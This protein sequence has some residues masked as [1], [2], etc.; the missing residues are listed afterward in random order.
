MERTMNRMMLMRRVG[1]Y[2]S[3]IDGYPAYG[4]SPHQR[5]CGYPAYWSEPYAEMIQDGSEPVRHSGRVPQEHS[6][7]S[8]RVS[9]LYWESALHAMAYGDTTEMESRRRRWSSSVRG[10]DG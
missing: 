4:R 3:M 6:A 5:D 7:Y 2:L 8:D 10:L 9:R 1:A